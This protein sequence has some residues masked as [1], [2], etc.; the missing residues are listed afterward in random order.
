VVNPLEPLPPT[1]IPGGAQRSPLNPRNRNQS[2]RKVRFSDYSL[3]VEGVLVDGGVE[4]VLPVGVVAGVLVEGV[5]AGVEEVVVC[6]AL[7]ETRYQPIRITRI[8]TPT[9]TT[10]MLRWVI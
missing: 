4:G 3:G 1:A 10:M 8:T 2:R 5:V 9:A 7:P 6:V